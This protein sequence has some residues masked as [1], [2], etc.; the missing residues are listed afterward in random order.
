MTRMSRVTASLCGITLALILLVT[1]GVVSHLNEQAAKEGY[2]RNLRAASRA[3]SVRQQA[4]E[5]APNPPDQSAVHVMI[6]VPFG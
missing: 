2:S 4:L 5:R 3:A 6:Q 1:V